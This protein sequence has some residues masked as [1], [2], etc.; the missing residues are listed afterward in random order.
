M[1]AVIFR[2]TIKRL[3]ADYDQVSKRMRE[4]AFKDYNCADFTA[5][6]E[7]HDEIAI[8]YWHSL[9]D[10]KAWRK[11]PEHIEAIKRGKNDWFSH[12]QI[13]VV[14]IKRAYQS[15]IS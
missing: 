14:E 7:G 11:N 15:E 6:V 8:S 5:V 9:D 2:S 4:L 1:Y 13:E 10:I 3:D 12:F